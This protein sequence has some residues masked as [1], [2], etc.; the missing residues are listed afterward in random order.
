MVVESCY[1]SF[2]GLSLIKYKSSTIGLENFQEFGNEK[3]QATLK[4]M[5]KASDLRT[6]LVNTHFNRS[7]G[8]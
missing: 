2:N 3:C 7:F 1:I 6:L 4:R 5:A 8:I